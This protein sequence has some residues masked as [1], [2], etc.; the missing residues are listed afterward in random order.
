MAEA[1]RDA[2]AE[3]A[4]DA[5]AGA[6]DGV[7]SRAGGVRRGRPAPG[8]RPRQSGQARRDRFVSRDQLLQK[9]EKAG[10]FLPVP[11]SM[12]ALAKT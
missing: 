10:K 8:A 5:A 4:R 1:A 12:S 6:A 7:P 3:A 2:A 9:S 11:H